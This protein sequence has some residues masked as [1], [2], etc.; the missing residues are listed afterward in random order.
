MWSF[1]QIESWVPYGDPRRWSSLSSS[2]RVRCVILRPARHETLVACAIPA[3][4][5]DIVSARGCGSDK[6]YGAHLLSVYSLG[7]RSPCCARV[8]CDTRIIWAHCAT[9]RGAGD[10]IFPTS[11]S[12]SQFLH[13]K[14]SFPRRRDGRE[15]MG[16]VLLAVRERLM[17]VAVPASYMRIHCQPLLHTTLFEIS[18]VQHRKIPF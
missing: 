4:Q 10:A 17:L 9:G 14:M 2:S 18:A 15:N 8:R 3:H 12:R 16:I 13:T 6:K 7:R 5:E 1:A 11:R